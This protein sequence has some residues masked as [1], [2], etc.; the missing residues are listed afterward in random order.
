MKISLQKA[1]ELLNAA[2]AV[3]IDNVVTYP[4]VEDTTEEP[5]HQFLHISWE[6]NAE[7]YNALFS[8]GNNQEVEVIGLSMFLISDEGD[9][10][11]ITL[12]QPWDIESEVRKG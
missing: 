4:S 3:I 11:E 8:E 12:L 7:E 1:I 5:D 2:S 6:E 10:E 9:K